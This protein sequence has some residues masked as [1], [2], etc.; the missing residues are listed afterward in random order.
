MQYVWQH[1]LWPHTRPLCTVDGRP[2]RVINP[3]TLNPDAGPDFFNAQISI[4]GHLWAGDVEIHVKASDWYR[5]GHHTDDA[6]RGVILHVIDCDDAP[7]H[8]PDGSVI[9]Q[10][11][12]PCNGEFR[13]TYDALVA[14]SASGLPCTETIR[15]MDSLHITDWTQTLAY[16]RLY[17]RAD[18]V[19]E[20]LQRLNGDWESACYI[21]LARALG[22]GIN[23][24]C[25]ERLAA[26]TPLN[27]LGH[28]ADDPHI[29]ESILFGQSGLLE[30][31]T[32]TDPYVSSL[33]REYS[34]MAHKFGLRPMA[35]PLWK[36]ARMRPANFPHRRIAILAAILAD[37]FRMLSRVLAVNSPDDARALFTP[38]LTG[39]WEHHY[40]L[41]DHYHDSVPQGLG[42]TA[43]NA[44][45]INVAAVLKFAYGYLTG[46]DRQCVAAVD[47]LT[48]LPAESNRL[49][50]PFIT[51]G[52]ACPDA[53]T[54]QALIQLHRA[55]CEAHKCLYCRIGHRHL[56]ANSL[57]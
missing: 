36:M 38:V 57:R 14:S 19:S 46:T 13:S 22:F 44:L 35:A 1:R 3:G 45:C 32:P 12:L 16:E 51:A 9:D 6:Y 55:Y 7:V 21:T 43:V 37:G 41:S 23:G 49:V 47:L 48:S 31:A 52:V 54:S 56:A 42:H 39:Y 17:E 34:F 26:A 27:I 4:G 28:H 20:L 18:R 25:F 40:H 8:R 10:L 33:Q 29:I 53:F 30:G 5:H 15:A 2:V 11:R 24:D 50:T